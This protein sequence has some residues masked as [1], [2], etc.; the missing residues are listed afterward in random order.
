M[1]LYV[2][3]PIKRPP[4]HNRI[5]INTV[6]IVKTISLVLKI[7]EV[8]KCN[9]KMLSTSCVLDLAYILVGR[10]YRAPK[11]ADLQAHSHDV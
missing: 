8:V 9:P 3:V 4:K 7:N 1:T 10:C 11:I 6:D 5:S 2:M